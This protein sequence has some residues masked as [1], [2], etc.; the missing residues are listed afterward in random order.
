MKKKYMRK[1]TYNNLIFKINANAN[2]YSIGEGKKII[3]NQLNIKTS[4][5][6]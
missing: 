1:L 5:E 2:E 4:R 3:N 6:C